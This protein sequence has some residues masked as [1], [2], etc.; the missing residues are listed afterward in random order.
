MCR[1]HYQNLEESVSERLSKV[2]HAGRELADLCSKNE[3]DHQ[4][5]EI[6][7]KSDRC[8]TKTTREIA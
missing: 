2:G 4:M 8:S 5:S 3:H 1:Q 6:N 7:F